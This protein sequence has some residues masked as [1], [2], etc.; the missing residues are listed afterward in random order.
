MSAT[1]AGYIEVLKTDFAETAVCSAFYRA[2]VE[3][4]PIVLCVPRDIQRQECDSDGDDYQPSST[5]FTGQQKIQPD[6]D[7]LNEA[8]KM[9]AASKKPVLVLGRGAMSP[10]AV[11]AADRLA[12]RIGALISTT[13]LAKGTLSESEYH[14]G[15]SGLFSTR[16]VMHLLQ[17][18]DCVIAL[19][20]VLNERTIE[21]GHLYPNARIIHVNV[22]PHVLMGNCKSADCY[23]QADATVTLQA[24][25]AMLEK[26]G[27]SK[28][29]YRTAE[30]Q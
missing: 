15:I 6:A 11:A 8:V 23:I 5:L 3:S 1:G 17:E 29:G 13:L 20:A 7:R 25:D 16:S 19:G 14:A 22:A 12:K 26:Q 2:K 18:A 28:T 10:E 27:V 24:M 30:V 4:R 9:I 21:G